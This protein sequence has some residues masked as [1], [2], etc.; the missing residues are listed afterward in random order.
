[1]ETGASEARMRKWRRRRKRKRK[2]QKLLQHSFPNGIALRQSSSW[3]PRLKQ[4]KLHIARAEAEATAKSLSR[5]FFVSQGWKWSLSGSGVD[6]DDD[7]ELQ[8]EVIWGK[9]WFNFLLEN[10]LMRSWRVSASKDFSL[11]SSDWNKSMSTSSPRTCLLLESG[12][13]A[14]VLQLPW[15]SP[16]QSRQ[17]LRTQTWEPGRQPVGDAPHEELKLMACWS[18]LCCR[19]LREERKRKRNVTAN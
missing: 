17:R 18:F 14:P 16:S 19:G 2:L 9:N 15:G 1:M 7:E 4:W 11:R 5:G 12:L 6:Q 10:S 13:G 3:F 8:S